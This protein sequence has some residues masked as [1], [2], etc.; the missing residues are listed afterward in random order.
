MCAAWG[1]RATLRGCI[2][3]RSLGSI[4]GGS[5]RR[6]GLVADRF[7]AAWNRTF[8]VIHRRWTLGISG[9]SREPL[10][11]DDVSMTFWFGIGPT[12]LGINW[13]RIETIRS[14]SGITVKSAV[15][16]AVEDDGI[17]LSSWGNLIHGFC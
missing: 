14:F 9:H 13:V 1:E 15:Q 6:Q 2:S 8:A 5:Q 3:A 16:M 17:K 10:G 7:R 4:R 12:D 11:L